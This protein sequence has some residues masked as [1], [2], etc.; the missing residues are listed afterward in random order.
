MTTEEI[1]VRCKKVVLVVSPLISLMKNQVEV[2]TRKG[3]SA[4]CLTDCQKSADEEEIYRVSIFVLFP[5]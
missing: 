3:V 1:L 2:L 4:I 5:W